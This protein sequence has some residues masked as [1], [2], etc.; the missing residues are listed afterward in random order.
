M[1][2]CYATVIPV[3]EAN[4]QETTWREGRDSNTKHSTGMKFNCL[5]EKT[6]CFLFNKI[7]VKDEKIAAVTV[8][9]FRNTFFKVLFKTWEKREQLP[10]V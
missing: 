6:F 1:H 7:M 2:H 8:T 10:S 9:S 4:I 3:W 5:V